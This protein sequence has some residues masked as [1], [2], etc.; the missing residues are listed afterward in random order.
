M[1]NRGY[2][3]IELSVVVV[4]VG[5]MLLI[6]VPRVWDTLL[7]DSLNA[8]TRRLINAARELRSESV[9]EQTDLILHIDLDRQSFWFY[10][11]DTT[12]EKRSELRKAAFELPEGVRIAGIRQ[13]GEARRV[14]GEAFIRFFRQ[15]YAAPAVIHLT[16]DDRVF[17]VVIH[18][19]L[20][21][22]TVYEKYVDFT[23]NE[24]E[25]GAGL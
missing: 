11:A 24:E 17:T 2:T 15:G 5:T 6:A 25:S 4:L 13:A 18:P 14:D 1:N 7:N 22:A 19:F 23:F 3:L 21:A 16:K 9:R 20:Q 12:A 10:P 8:V